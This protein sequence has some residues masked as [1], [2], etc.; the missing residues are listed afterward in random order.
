[1]LTA[2]LRRLGVNGRLQ[3][4]V[5]WQVLTLD[6]FCSW[7]GFPTKRTTESLVAFAVFTEFLGS[8]FAEMAGHCSCLS[9]A[10]GSQ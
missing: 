3:R 7:K 9:S 4:F 8:I 5:D 6:A 10:I 1:L 2:E